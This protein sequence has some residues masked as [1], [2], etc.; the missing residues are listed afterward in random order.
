MSFK[1]RV[2]D[3][4]TRSFHWALALSVVGL[5]ISGN[6]GG[7]AMLWHMRLGYFVAS[8]LLFR[9]VWG[10]VGGYWSRFAQLRLAPQALLGYLRGRSGQAP[11][12]HLGHSPTGS[13]SVVALLS[14]LFAQVTAGLFSDD[15]IFTAGPLAAHASSDVVSSATFYHTGP[16]KLAVVLLVVAHVAAI[17]FY[18]KKKKRNLLPAMVYGDHEG[19]VA[20]DAPESVD[21]VAHALFGLVVWLVCAGVVAALVSAYG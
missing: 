6:V 17:W 8:L 4:P 10:F 9:V 14:L 1:H 2:W 5:F 16:G 7:N 11:H 19:V 12:D 13:W 18:A 20:V 3:L 15:D 21:G